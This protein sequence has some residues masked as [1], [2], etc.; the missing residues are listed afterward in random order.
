MHIAAVEILT[1]GVRKKKIHAIFSWIQS[2]STKYYAYARMPNCCQFTSM[3]KGVT[4]N[5]KK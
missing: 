4:C 3:I 5:K 2:Q 1:F